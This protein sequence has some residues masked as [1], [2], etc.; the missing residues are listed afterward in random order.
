MNESIPVLSKYPYNIDKKN[1]LFIPSKI[2]EA[3]GDPIIIGPDMR[4]DALVIYS[5]EEWQKINE[6][7]EKLP[8]RERDIL[9]HAFNS[10]C[11]TFTPDTQGRIT[12]NQVLVDRAHLDGS[13]I[14]EGLGKKAR[15]WNS[16][17][18]N[19][20]FTVEVDAEAIAD[21]ADKADI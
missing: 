18:F 12:L 5:L 19:K 11:D 14:I 4:E 3:L 13:V 15:I 9:L 2:K 1:R 21:L 6:K 8:A 17:T 7:I 20:R 10:N 16:E